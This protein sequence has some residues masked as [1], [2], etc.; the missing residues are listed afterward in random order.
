MG[1]QISEKLVVGGVT[2]W[3]TSRPGYVASHTSNADL[4]LIFGFSDQ[5]E[6]RAI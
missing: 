5:S 2:L 6:A 3:N 1:R 4:W